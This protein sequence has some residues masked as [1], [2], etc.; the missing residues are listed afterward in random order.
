MKINI[1][2]EEDIQISTRHL[3]VQGLHDTSELLTNCE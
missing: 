2:V 3:Y 1:F